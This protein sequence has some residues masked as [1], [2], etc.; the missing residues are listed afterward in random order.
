MFDTIAPRYGLVNRLLTFGL[1]EGWRRR[2]VAE[3]D[4]EPGSTVLDLASGPGELCVAL[5]RRGHTSIGIDLSMGMLRAARTGAPMV[6][7]DLLALPVAD[8]A[9]DG[10]VCGFALRNLVALPPFLDELA[11]V[12]RPGGR[13]G[14]LDV[15]QPDN[16]LLRAGHSLYFNRVVPLV[17]GAL[18]DRDAYAYL[19]RSVSYLPPPAELTAMVATAGFD[20]VHRSQLSTGI[21]QLITA[22][23]R[24]A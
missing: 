8:R 7:G 17:G 2:T 11:R 13:I 12:V 23:R 21:S 18:S 4:L 10:A 14:L 19:P 3:L 6:Q 1:D 5:E 20:E 24:P 15:S 22:T 16:R 9:V